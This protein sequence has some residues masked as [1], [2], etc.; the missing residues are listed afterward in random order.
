[1]SKLAEILKKYPNCY[2]NYTDNGSYYIYPSKEAYDAKRAENDAY[3]ENDSEGDEPDFADIQ[4]YSGN[5]W[6]DANGYA[7]GLV[8]ELARL[9][10][11]TVDSV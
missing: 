11:K 3:W 6:D 1:M 9:T 2:I 10:G 8:V 4:V 5:H 7:P